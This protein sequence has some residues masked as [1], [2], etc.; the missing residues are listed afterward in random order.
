[1]LGQLQKAHIEEVAR[2]AAGELARITSA[3][4]KAAI[5][6]ALRSTDP[7]TANDRLKEVALKASTSQRTG[8]RN[9]QAL[10][11]VQAAV[12]GLLSA[13]T[14]SPSNGNRTAML[15]LFARTLRARRKRGR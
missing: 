11:T 2:V 15:G 13:W 4:L 7:L 1:M 12:Q 10:R 3:P 6:R 9:A 14:N 5:S 8:E